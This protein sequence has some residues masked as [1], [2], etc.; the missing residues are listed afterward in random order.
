MTSIRSSYGSGNS[1]LPAESSSAKIAIPL[2]LDH[3][4]GAEGGS[5]LSGMESS[6]LDP[7]FLATDFGGFDGLD[8]AFTAIDAGIR[9]GGF[10]DGDGGGGGG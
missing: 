1:C 2:I 4:L 9:A 3:P 10:G 7:G 8:S 6:N 5:E